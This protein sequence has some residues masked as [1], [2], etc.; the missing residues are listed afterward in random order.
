MA[1][2]LFLSL[3]SLKD[4]YFVRFLL[5]CLVLTGGLLASSVYGADWWLAHSQFFGDGFF[6]RIAQKILHWAGT[7]MATVMAW[8]LAPLLFP[9]ISTL[10]LDS[11]VG[12]IETRHY[13]L[14][15]STGIP[16]GRSLTAALRLLALALCLNLLLLPL[17][18]LLP[19]LY[20]PLYYLLNGYLHGREYVE[21]V[22]LRYFP[23]REA[24]QLRRR[25][26]GRVLSAGVI[27]MLLFTTPFINL[28]APVLSAVF[29]AHVYHRVLK[30]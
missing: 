5:L 29:M 20:L 12:R 25:Q 14:P 24:R 21:L 6:G 10:F 4:G 9:L 23:Q 11:V 27:V 16:L 8:F 30:P 7:G 22:A 3:R 15:R 26:R 18:F 13:G 17:M 2:I 1:T 19:I 28:L